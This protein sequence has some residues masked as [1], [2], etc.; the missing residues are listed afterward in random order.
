MYLRFYPAVFGAIL[1]F[2]LLPLAGSG[3]FWHLLDKFHV[4]TC[5]KTLM[6]SMLT[7]NFY[8]LDL[9]S[10]YHTSM[11]NIA[12]WWVNS[13]FHLILLSPL[14]ILPLYYTGHALWLV[15]SVLLFGSA[16]SAGHIW[17][18]GIPFMNQ[19]ALM[20]SILEESFYSLFYTWPFIHHVGPFTAGI[21]VGYL[22]RR[23]PKVYLGGAFGETL[24]SIVFV[25]LSALGFYWTQDM[26]KSS[27]DIVSLPNG[28]SI[29]VYLNV[30]VG[31]LM[32]CAGFLW[33]FY[34]C[35]TNRSGKL[36]PIF[37]KLIQYQMLS[38]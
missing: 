28:N 36:F 11:C 24:L 20:N 12:T 9:E 30:T 21:L 22:I 13:C 5:R 25:G 27:S 10:F 26:L 1:F 7:Y 16:L 4:D 3:P 2:Y 35:C 31:K 23:H 37:P 38:F 29:E 32:F 15:L 34:L 18:K 19:L 6:E 8:I 17:Y 14:L 33:I